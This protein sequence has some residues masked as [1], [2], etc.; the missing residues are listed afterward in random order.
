MEGCSDIIVAQQLGEVGSV[1]RRAAGHD[2]RLAPCM[3]L[4][5]HR[6]QRC[7]EPLLPALHLNFLQEQQ[8]VSL[9]LWVTRFVEVEYLITSKKIKV[10]MIQI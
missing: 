6:G 3:P 9:M 4:V 2:N 5:H 1:V 7:Q 8:V 10:N